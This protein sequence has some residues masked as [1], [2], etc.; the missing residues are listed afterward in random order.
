MALF[1]PGKAAAATNQYAIQLVSYAF[2]SGQWRLVQQVVQQYPALTGSL[3]QGVTDANI[4][5]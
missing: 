1:W 3:V 4:M 2:S 5:Q